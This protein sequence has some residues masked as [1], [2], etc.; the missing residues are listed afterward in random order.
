VAIPRWLLF[1]VAAWV[2]AFGV[3][4]IYIA[5]RPRRTIG[6]GPNFMRRGMYARSGRT[7]ALFGV[8]Y[9]LLGGFLI[10]TG[11]GWAPVMDLASCAGKP[12]STSTVPDSKD[13]VRVI[14]ADSDSASSK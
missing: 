10:A 14:P 13:S 7:H 5:L 2:I 8:V 12:D 3:F 9:L 1:L 4:R 6:E 11:F